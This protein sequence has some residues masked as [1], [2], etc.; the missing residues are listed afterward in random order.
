MWTVGKIALRMRRKLTC[1]DRTDVPS[2]GDVA[3]QQD[4]KPGGIPTPDRQ[5]PE[6]QAHKQELDTQAAPS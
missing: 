4:D 5:R 3:K 1:D 2:V 6:A